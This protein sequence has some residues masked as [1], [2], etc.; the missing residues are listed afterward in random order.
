MSTATYIQDSDFETL[1]TYEGPL[2]IDFT[3][4]WCGPCRKIAPLIDQLAE[5]YEGRA[6]VFKIDLDKNK[7]IAKQ[8]GVRSIPAVLVFKGGE[9]VEN[10][11]GVAPYE[12]FTT[13]LEKHLEGS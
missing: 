7:V 13:A 10:M 5:E 12:T 9:L 3:A 8:F 11:V 6:K 1:I 2:V 4:S